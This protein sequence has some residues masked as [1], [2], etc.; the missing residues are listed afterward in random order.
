MRIPDRQAELDA[1]VRMYLS[2]PEPEP[3]GNGRQAAGPRPELSDDE[4]ISLCRKAKNA[5]KFSDLYDAGDT[6]AHGGDESRAD[7]AL[8][9]MFKFYTQDPA[10]IERLMDGSALGQRAKW[11]SRPD[12]R[13]RTVERALRGL[14]E[15]Y[16]PPRE[17]GRTRT[18]TPNR[19]KYGYTA[20]GEGE[21]ERPR[22]RSLSFAEMGKPKE[23]VY[24]VEGLVPEA[25]PTLFY[26]DGGVAKSMIAL[27]LAMALARKASKWLGL[28]VAGGPVLYLDFELD[29]HEQHR[30]VAQLA[31][32]EGLDGPPADLR[33][34]SAL[35]FPPHEAFEAALAECAEHRIK[36]V[37]IDSLGPA[38]EGDA[39]A[40]RDVIGFYQKVIEPFRAAGVTI[41]A[42]DHQ[43]KL[44][45]GERYQ[46]K[47]A[48]GSVFK[49]NLARSVVQVEA[50]NREDGAL[51]VRVRQIK[52]NFGK[53][54][55]PFGIELSFSEEQV[56]LDRMELGAEDLREEDTLNSNDRVLLAL[57]DGPAF[58]DAVAEST[59]LAR[60]TVKNALTKLRREELVEPTGERER[61]AEQVRLT[62]AGFA[63]A[64]RCTRTSA[65]K[66][67]GTGTPGDPRPTVTT[68]DVAA[69]F[70]RPGSGARK[71]LAH[72]LR[73]DTTLEILARSVL[74]GLG[75]DAGSWGR[76]AAVVEE[77][78]RD[79]KNHPIECEC[80]ECG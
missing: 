62:G 53:L 20:G 7:L 64:A 67:T 30:R 63:A 3:S 61:Q 72:Y 32:A 69:E 73:G 47:R 66:G 34:M 76:C 33:Y 24:L 1:L 25:Y 27:S 6:A 29:A 74:V 10:Q 15:T 80:E 38:L 60:Q 19:D 23:R 51:T 5:A 75:Q 55:D 28:T 42:V 17:D 13:K 43:S 56:R 77:T 41:A 70:N 79:P 71:N 44:Q 59:G 18:R 58:P 9:G 39:E 37:I 78:A 49:G 50:T 11:R 16:T 65:Y 2:D 46:N 22:L 52:H 35:G 68:R 26:G 40:A 45:A 4:I 8:A 14:G 54:A 21:A 57:V 36:L 31:R 48:F 12:Y